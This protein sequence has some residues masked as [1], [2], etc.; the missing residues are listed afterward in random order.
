VI[1]LQNLPRIRVDFN[2]LVEPGLVLL[3]KHD[4]VLSDD[5]VEWVL[6][7]GLPLLAFESNAYG[8]GTPEYLFVQGTAERNDPERNGEW[9]RPARWCCRFEGEVQRAERQAFT[10]AAGSEFLKR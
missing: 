10:S 1:P 2:E 6:L 3:A 9:T 7:P 8:D 4:Q 5:G